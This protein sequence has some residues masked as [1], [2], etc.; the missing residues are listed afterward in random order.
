MAEVPTGTDRIVAISMVAHLERLVE[1]S[2]WRVLKNNDDKIMERLL[3][4][5]GPLSSFSSKIAMAF[6]MGAIDADTMADLDR[7]RAIR[8][9]FAHAAIT[10]TFDTNLVA[11][12]C[13]KLKAFRF[14][15]LDAAEQ[16]SAI[17][18]ATPRQLFVILTVFLCAEILKANLIGAA[19]LL[20]DRVV[21]AGD[22]ERVASTV[23]SVDRLF[24]TI[25]DLY[26]FPAKF[27]TL[28]AKHLA[29]CSG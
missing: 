20:R 23:A 8:N 18:E 6:A 26:D 28:R 1:Q 16:K 24:A 12:E 10:V 27:K 4:D 11:R 29:T 14:F 7:A 21:K 19:G 13:R 25:Y 3:S 9:V 17:S 15:G 5:H 22:A 2:I